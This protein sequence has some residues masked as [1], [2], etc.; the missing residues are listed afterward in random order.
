MSKKSK[1]D[2]FGNFPCNKISASTKNP[3]K[4][5]ASLESSHLE[6]ADVDQLRAAAKN[7][8]RLPHFS[9]NC[10]QSCK[11]KAEN[12]SYRLKTASVGRF[13]GDE[14]SDRNAYDN[15]H[16]YYRRIFGVLLGKLCKVLAVQGA[17]RL[18]A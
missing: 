6:P 18:F 2:D 10:C 1:N 8:Y 16:D 5:M 3:L 7:T 17:G 13:T 14:R 4:I 12:K 9:R 11:N 15:Q